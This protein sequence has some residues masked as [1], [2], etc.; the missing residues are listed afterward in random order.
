MLSCHEVLARLGDWLDDSI[1]AEARERLESHMA[2]CRTCHAVYDTSRK[3]LRIVT[4][5]G[6]FELPGSLSSRIMERLRSTA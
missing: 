4:D 6:S 5:S 3:T 2:E 1:A